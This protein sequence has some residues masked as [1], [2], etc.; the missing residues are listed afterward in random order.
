MDITKKP[1]GMVI[2]IAKKVSFDKP[3]FLLLEKKK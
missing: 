1:G 3:F 2:E